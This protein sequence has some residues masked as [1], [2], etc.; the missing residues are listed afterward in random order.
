M[1]L[2][3]VLKRMQVERSVNTRMPRSLYCYSLTNGSWFSSPFNSRFSSH[4]CCG[5]VRPFVLTP[6]GILFPLKV[7]CL[8]YISSFHVFQLR[9]RGAAPSE[10]IFHTGFFMG[11][12]QYSCMDRPG[13]SLWPAPAQQPSTFHDSSAHLNRIV[14][15][16]DVAIWRSP[17]NNHEY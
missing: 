6:L 1:G 2:V 4:S 13:P 8:L 16:L 15:L 12:E 11:R 9:C 17:S 14:W 7:P 10:V 5:G 3:R